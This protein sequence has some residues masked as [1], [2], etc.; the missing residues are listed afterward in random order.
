[1]VEPSLTLKRL[2]SNSA[3][4]IHRRLVAG[5]ICSWGMMWVSKRALCSTHPCCAIQI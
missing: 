3:M 5:P 2:D 4:L 1:M